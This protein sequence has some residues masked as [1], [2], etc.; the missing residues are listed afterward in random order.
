MSISDNAFIGA[1][2]GGL[3]ASIAPVTASLVEHF[4]RRREY[5][6]NV[7]SQNQIRADRQSDMCRILYEEC[8]STAGDFLGYLDRARQG[9]RVA[10]TEARE[11]RGKMVAAWTR[12]LRDASTA[13]RG[14][15][16][17]FLSTAVGDL[18]SSQLYESTSSAIIQL[19]DIGTDD[20]GRMSVVVPTKTSITVIRPD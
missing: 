6:F 10:Y 3:I 7:K 18:N 9:D 11:A 14:I 16:R 2:A 15:I 4:N 1:L 13:E 17:H 19:A 12:Y 20:I 8:L 5:D